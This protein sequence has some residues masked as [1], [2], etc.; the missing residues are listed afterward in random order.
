MGCQSLISQTTTPAVT[1][2][3]AREGASRCASAQQAV[4]VAVY[5][6]G[7]EYR[8]EAISLARVV[9][10]REPGDYFGWLALGRLET[11]PVLARRAQDRALAL[12]PRAKPPA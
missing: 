8:R 1:A 10:R 12:N 4:L 6:A 2:R 5:L 7:H 9:V 11:D 3:L